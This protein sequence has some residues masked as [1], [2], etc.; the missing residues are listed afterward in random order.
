MKH[1]I[2]AALMLIILIGA[3]A[4]FNLPGKPLPAG[5]AVGEKL[6]DFAAACLDGEEYRLSA[7]E[8]KIVVIN[9]WAAWCGPCVQELPEFA[10][11]L[12]AHSRDVSVL[13]VHSEM[14]TEDVP[15]WL[16]NREGLSSLRFCVDGDGSL[17]ALLGASDALPHTVI[18]DRDGVVIYNLPGSMTLD[19][20]EQITQDALAQP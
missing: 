5:F 16:E 6:P 12:S 7:Q 8:G 15:A 3:L 14:V 4:Y 1:K 10:A 9:L 2:T 19:K 17:S 20:L 18:L 13:A 11:F